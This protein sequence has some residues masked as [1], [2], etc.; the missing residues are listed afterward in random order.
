MPSKSCF[1]FRKTIAVSGLIGISASASFLG[2][3]STIPTQGLQLWLRADAGVKVAH[4][5]VSEWHDNSEFNNAARQS[6]SSSQPVLVSNAVN[7]KPAVQFD[8]AQTFMN[9]SLPLS[10]LQEITIIL[11]SANTQNQNGG[12]VGSSNSAISWDETG[13]WGTVHLSP[14]QSSVAYRF[15][16]GQKNNQPIYK[17]S[18]SLD[19]R[20]SITTSVKN[21]ANEALFVNGANVLKQRGKL[22]GLAKVS[23]NAHLGRGY[24]GYFAGD[25]AELLIYARA[26]SATERAAVENYLYTKYIDW[27]SAH[28]NQAPSVSAGPN[29]TVKIPANAALNATVSD[30]GLPSGKLTISWAGVSGP[31]SVDF[32]NAA[33]ALT[34]ATFFAPGTY[35]LTVT[36]SDG[37]LTSSSDVTVTVAAA[38]DPDPQAS[39]IYPTK[40]YIYPSNSGFYSVK[41]YGAKGDGTTDDTSAIIAAMHAARANCVNFCTDQTVYF[42]KGTYLVSDTLWWKDTAGKWVSAL[43]FEGQNRDN[44]TIKLKDDTFTNSSCV[45][46][47]SAWPLCRAVIYT[48]NETTLVA[49]TGEQG[50]KNDIWN[51]TVDTGRGNT[52]AVGIDWQCSNRCEIK[53]VNVI[54]G[55]GQGKAGINVSLSYRG[56]SGQGPG[57]IKNVLVHGLDYGIYANTPAGEVGIT[58]EY[59]DMQEQNVAGFYNGGMPNWVRKVSSRNKVPAFVNCSPTGAFGAAHGCAKS[60]GKLVVVDAVL[61]GGAADGSAILIENDQPNQGTTFLRNITATGYQAALATSGGTYAT[62]NAIAEYSFPA[63]ITQFGGPVLSLNMA[64]IPNTPELFDNNFGTADID[65]DGFSVADCGNMGPNANS[66]GDWADVTCYGASKDGTGDQTRAIQSAMNSGRP[67]IYFP[68]GRYALSGTLHIPSTVRK[69]LGMHS[70]IKSSVAPLFS[71]ESTSGL[72][73]EIRLFDMPHSASPAFSNA[74]TGPM[75]IANVGQNTSGYRD[76]RG[77]NI[78][79]FEDYA[80]P[81]PLT[82]DHSTVYARQFDIEGGYPTFTNSI[83]WLFGYKTEAGVKCGSA[84]GACGLFTAFGGSVEIL[85]A[86]HFLNSN[87]GEVNPEYS[88][89]DT[90]FSVSGFYS[91]L[92]WNPTIRETRGGLTRTYYGAGTGF[93]QCCVSIGVYSGHN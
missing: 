13:Y 36:A 32:S 24:T 67:V 15:G 5:R 66:P 70:F 34:T 26:L 3:K 19:S 93:N 25:V 54:S 30:D 48:A 84:S 77:G 31:G 78:V 21:G 62:G 71:C 42:P 74:C 41:K 6:I 22:S 8:G 86:Q 63:G 88:I 17:R 27:P 40:D 83:G 90:S 35:T 2:G 57:M 43:R 47:G 91:A 50:Y 68:W 85:G 33:S 37:S 51:L 64:N 72:S 23:A 60:A 58:F 9:F 87:V 1:L 4:N 81:Y 28:V 45:I 46:G 44:T 73:V 20:F 80:G 59:I 52:E 76:A 69:V 18:S 55:D 49:G 56:L 10:G 14:F 65:F 38:S 16:T 11:V 89:T 12:T 61:T 29:Q 75:I 82:F 7:G 39:F 53:N 92:G 79:F